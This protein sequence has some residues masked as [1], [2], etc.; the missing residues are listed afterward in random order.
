ME[1]SRCRTGK[2]KKSLHSGQSQTPVESSQRYAGFAASTVVESLKC[3]FTVH[4]E[5][6]FAMSPRS[7]FMLMC[8][9][10]YRSLVAAKS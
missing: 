6:L 10:R 1:F 5:E 4:D 2:P 8:F 9:F 3:V 7:C